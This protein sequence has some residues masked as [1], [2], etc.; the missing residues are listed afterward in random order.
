[1]WLVLCG[2]VVVV[3]GVVGVVVFQSLLVGLGC[4]G[5]SRVGLSRVGLGQVGFGGVDAD[6]RCWSRSAAGSP[7][8]T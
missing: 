5:L 3:V 4:V 8:S 1:M 7:P 6:A 2:V